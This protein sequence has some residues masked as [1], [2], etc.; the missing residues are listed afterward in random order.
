[1]PKPSRQNLYPPVA[2]DLFCGGLGAH[3]CVLHPHT[4][5]ETRPCT[6]IKPRPAVCTVQWCELRP[7]PHCIRQRRSGPVAAAGGGF[8]VTERDGTRS[9]GRKQGRNSSEGSGEGQA[10]CR[11]L[12]AG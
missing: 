5:T 11:L 1:M 2:T 12:D 9:D 10:A 6:G 3:P 8:D 7:G 4:R